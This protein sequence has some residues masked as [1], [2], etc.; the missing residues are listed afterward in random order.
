MRGQSSELKPGQNVPDSLIFIW[1]CFLKNRRSPR[2]AVSAEPKHLPPPRSP[3]W[4]SGGPTG[5]TPRGPAG[6]PNACPGLGAGGWAF[7]NFTFASMQ[8]FLTLLSLELE[9]WRMKKRGNVALGDRMKADIS[10]FAIWLTS[11]SRGWE[12]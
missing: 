11:S 4:V 2:P 6:T 10:H 8:V 12:V 9:A 7:C 3:F 5:G 1:F